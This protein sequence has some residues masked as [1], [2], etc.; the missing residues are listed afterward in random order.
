MRAEPT[1]GAGGGGGGGAGGGDGGGGGDAETL[2][3]TVC[4]ADPPLPAQTSVYVLAASSGPVDCE[5]DV[6]LVP[7]QAPDAWQLLAFVESQRSID[8]PPLATE[9][10]SAL[11]VTVGAGA[12]PGGGD[13]DTVIVTDW[14]AVEPSP[15]QVSV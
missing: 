5:P 4:D 15:V 10:G 3:V 13:D 12:G 2:T 8:A 14:L 7:D 9:G 11:R 1:G 6:G